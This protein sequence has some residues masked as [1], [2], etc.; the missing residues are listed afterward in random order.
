MCYAIAIEKKNQQQALYTKILYKICRLKCQVCSGSDMPM[1]FQ[2]DINLI[3]CVQQTRGKVT[4]SKLFF[5]QSIINYF[6]ATC[7][8][9]KKETSHNIPD[10]V[11]IHVNKLYI[12]LFV[13]ICLL[14]HQIVCIHVCCS[15][16]LQKLVKNIYVTY[17]T[18]RYTS[19]TFM[20]CHLLLLAM[21]K[22]FIVACEK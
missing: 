22:Y 4:V 14:K 17:R 20:K 1:I 13:V 6:P 9:S 18:A 12:T 11:K 19:K 8:N 15:Q 3:R 16:S 2:L 5:V 7:S 10:F 21:L